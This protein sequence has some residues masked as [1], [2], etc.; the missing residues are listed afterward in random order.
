M[1]EK[2]VLV[3]SDTS[4]EDSSFCFIQCLSKLY[5]SVI[6]QNIEEAVS[7]NISEDIFRVISAKMNIPV[8]INITL[9]PGNRA[10]VPDNCFQAGVVFGN[11]FRIYCR[12]GNYGVSRF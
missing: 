6:V 8:V 1:A 4:G 11:L 12:N 9:G 2:H 3:A 10:S 5:S 7:L